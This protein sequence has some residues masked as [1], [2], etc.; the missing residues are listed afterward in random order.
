[1][2]Y[3][4][5]TNTIPWIAVDGLRFCGAARCGVVEVEL[6]ELASASLLGLAVNPDD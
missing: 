3:Q 4:P 5:T 6:R 1:M 2:C